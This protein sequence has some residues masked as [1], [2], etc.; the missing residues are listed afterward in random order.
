V[1]LLDVIIVVLLLTSV[2]G[3]W[4]LG[5][6]TG[7]TSW[8]LL[9]QSLVAATL[10]MPAVATTVGGDDPGVRLIVAA[11]VFV[12]AGVGGQRVG[13]LVGRQFRRAL[14]GDQD[15]LRFRDKVA[16]AAAAPIAVVVGLWLLILPPLG[17]VSG[18]LAG[19]S[20]DSAFARAIETA[21]PEPPETSQALRRLAGPAGAP[22]VFDGLI[23]AL[24][25]GPPPA[26]SGLAPAVV[27]RVAASTVKVEGVACRFERDGSGFTVATDLVVTNAHVVAGQRRT[28][29]VRPDGSRLRAEVTVFDPGRDLALLAVPGLGQAPLPVA[30]AKIGTTAAVFGHPAGQEDVEVSPASIRQQ[31]NAL[32]PDL[33]ELGM[34]RRSVL[35]L[36][37]EL[38][39]GDSGGAVVDDDGQVVGVAFAIS[40]DNDSTAYA[41]AT[42][43]LRAVLEAERQSPA[44]TGPCLS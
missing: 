29:V 24:E 31:V 4:R 39:P 30:A 3:G 19:L 44:P 2:G 22:H 42:S 9:M 20:R 7:A 41:L 11:L 5:L 17:E 38:A 13:I 14:L 37:A 40:P 27:A 16:G 36:A 26:D 18:S 33:Y 15:H 25:T 10:T 34:T 1:N 43:E 6:L 12:G 32:G 28:F 8:V 23:P 21:L 35:V